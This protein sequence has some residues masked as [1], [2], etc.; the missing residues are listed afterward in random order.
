MN[1]HKPYTLLNKAEPY[2]WIAPSIILMTIFIIVPIGF[3]FRMAFS[4][5]TKAGLVK[6]FIGFT[7][8]SKVLKSAK[9]AIVLK[10]TVVWTIVVVV[11]ST[12]LGFILALLLIP[13]WLHGST[14]SVPLSST[15]LP[16]QSGQTS[17]RALSLCS[18]KFCW[19]AMLR[20]C[21]MHCRLKSP[22]NPTYLI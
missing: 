19:A 1:K 7:N 14:L 6:G 15:P 21:W 17:S 20:N 5:V 12:V 16:R 22:A 9:F 18:R 4:Q 13:A 3:V 11:L 2:L 10:N 8:F